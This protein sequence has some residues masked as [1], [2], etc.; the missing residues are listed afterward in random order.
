MNVCVFTIALAEDYRGSL[1]VRQAQSYYY[2]E[3]KTKTRYL[4]IRGTLTNLGGQNLMVVE[5]HAA[6]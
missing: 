5:S 3:P 6:V 2:T 1:A 4:Q